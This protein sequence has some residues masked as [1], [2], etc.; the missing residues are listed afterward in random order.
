MGNNARC[1]PDGA[2]KDRYV[3]H[4]FLNC[5]GKMCSRFN[6]LSLCNSLGVLKSVICES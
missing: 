1:S 5:R 6:T 2:S 3:V 4:A